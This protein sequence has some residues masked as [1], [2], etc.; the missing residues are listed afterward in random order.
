MCQIVK[1]GKSK[2]KQM[3]RTEDANAWCVRTAARLRSVY[4]SFSEDQAE[5]RVGFLED[6]LEFALEE[7]EG[8]PGENRASLLK[9]LEWMF[10]SY[11]DSGNDD[12]ANEPPPTDASGDSRQAEPEELTMDAL[13]TALMSRSGEMTQ[14][15]LRDLAAVLGEASNHSPGLNLPP[16][17]DS[18]VSFPKDAAEIDDCTK[19]IHQL[20][21]IMNVEP[22]AQHELRLSRMVKMLAILTGAVRDLHSFAWMFWKESAP[23]EAAALIS[24]G[25]SGQVDAMVAD[26]VSGGQTSS[27]E[28]FKEIDKT[29]KVIIGLLFAC[30]RAGLDYG[31]QCERLYS[32]DAVETAVTTEETADSEAKVRDLDRKCWDRYKRLAQNRTAETMH[33]EFLRVLA[34]NVHAYMK[35]HA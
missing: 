14:A 33:D 2:V 7:G 23:R 8:I 34:E 3:T 29:K 27:G 24:S 10:P 19:A 18:Q 1:A 9:S 31:R 4:A 13:I 35:Q 30:H 28:F 32:P 26:Y 12:R 15:N 16:E 6:E 11:G 20:W 22:G 17:I 21:R 25:V 5:R